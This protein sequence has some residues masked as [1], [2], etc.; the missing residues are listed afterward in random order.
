MNIHGK[1][2]LVAGG[3]SGLGLA[4]ARALS[5]RGARVVVLGRRGELARQ[6]ASSLEDAIG[7]E[8]DLADD[9]SIAAAVA[10]TLDRFGALHININTAG[11][12]DN[13]PIVSPDGAATPVAEFQRLVS[14]NLV[15]TWSVMSRAAAAMICNE[16]DEGGERG[17]IVNTSSDAAY[18]GTVGQTGYAGTKAGIIGLT[19]PA[20]RDLG[21]HGIR[22]NAIVGGGFDT[23]ILDFATP[24]SLVEIVKEF[25][26]PK[27]LGN[28]EEFAALALHL[29]ENGYINS[30]ALRIDAGYRIGY[31]N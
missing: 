13:V 25:P 12:I 20:S 9:E 29:I 17:V 23:P 3:T 7:V 22:V 6:I 26:S 31:G 15:G 2:A 24:E 14:T 5:D 4:T 10:Q 16:P 8:A 11:I 21:S 30:A 18:D 28:P 19:L 27:R 1:V